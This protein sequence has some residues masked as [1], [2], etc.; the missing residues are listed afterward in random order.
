MTANRER[1]FDMTEQGFKHI[2]IEEDEEVFVVGAQAVPCAQEGGTDLAE[3]AFTTASHEGGAFR[4]AEAASVEAA[5]E[6]DASGEAAFAGTVPGDALRA[7]ADASG[8]MSPGRTGASD[9]LE[10][11][12]SAASADS[13][14]PSQNGWREPTMEDIKGEPM[15]LLQKVILAAAVVGVV[16]L[17]LYIVF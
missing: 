1:L 13:A 10:K 16:V 2:T 11:D 15:P 14:F 7:Y 8:R 12:V 6:G 5:L 4:S 3:A 9:P 17:V